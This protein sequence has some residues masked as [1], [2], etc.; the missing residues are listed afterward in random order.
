MTVRTSSLLPRN[1]MTLFLALPSLLA[2]GASAGAQER[3]PN[4]KVGT[5][6]LWAQGVD[7]IIHGKF[8]EAR[9]SLARILESKPSEE[10]YYEV[11]SW[12][13]RRS[14]DNAT[15]TDLQAKQRAQY[16]RLA[17]KHLAK[18][19]WEEAFDY[20]RSAGICSLA[21]A[22]FMREPWVQ[23]L[24]DE[25]VALARKHEKAGEWR[26]A[27]GLYYQLTQVYDGNAQYERKLDECGSHSRLEFLYGEDSEWKVKMRGVTP[28]IVEDA[29]WEIHRRYV[30]EPDLREGAKDGLRQLRLLAESD[31]LI[32][33][34]PGLKDEDDRRM[35]M[36][37]LD[38]QIKKVD[39]LE[40]YSY[41]HLQAAFEKVLEINDQTVEMDRELIIYEFFEKVLG[42]DGSLDKFTSM[43]WPVEYSEFEKHTQGRFYGVG[44]QISRLQNKLTVVTP[45]E[46]TPAYRAGIQ[47][48]DVISHVNGE[49]TEGL[50]LTG[51]VRTIMG[52]AGTEVVLTIYRPRTK[53]SFDVT[54]MREQ[55]EIQSVKGYRRSAESQE[56]DFML[57][58]DF[59]IGYIRLT[60]FQDTSIDELKVTMK[61]L[62]K[63]GMRGLILDLRFNPGGLLQSAIDVAEMFLP[64]GD[65]I[66]ST[67][68]RRLAADTKSSNSNDRHYKLPLVVLVNGSSASA[69]EIVAG[70]LKDH[71][72]ALVVG[73]RSFGKGSVQ[74]LI[75]VGRG[76]NAYLK[77]TTAQY[78]LPSGQ[79]IHRLPES[80][81]WGVEPDIEV[82][83]VVRETNK[84]RMM[85]RD[86]DIIHLEGDDAVEEAE[87]PKPAEDSAPAEQGDT[88]AKSGGDAQPGETASGTEVKTEDEAEEAEEPIEY[89]A[90][91]YQLETA[92]L[93][94]RVQ[95]LQKLGFGILPKVKLGDGRVPSRQPTVVT[96]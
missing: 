94:L 51:A 52:P 27:A 81:T 24:H 41:K 46:D 73:E 86:A 37:R 77:L 85:N 90:V 59:K 44:I 60:N 48:D 21:E 53:K 32:E 55:I 20:V 70:A 95:L 66:V 10:S 50:T 67:E 29:L 96:N 69:S 54:L 78:F 31:V 79:S 17:K 18:D 89:P 8:S 13:D 64:D 34:Y 11:A 1:C 12:L 62:Q 87:A 22:A 74:N 30:V 36:R 28:K 82:S 84:I 26:E 76:T 75:P 91:D 40:D 72:R 83:L 65:D 5:D 58:A 3:V 19:E 16:L 43:I 63:Q 14:R 61:Q 88:P 57:D 92:A 23:K 39:S 49:P 38:R 71:Q 15:R 9:A 4:R 47:A 42:S 68:G 7:G 93:V 45:L 35:Y 2:F 25:I 6:V 80:E 56:W 33:M